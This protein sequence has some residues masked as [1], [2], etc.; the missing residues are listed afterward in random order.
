MHLSCIPLDDERAQ[1]LM[2]LLDGEK[3]SVKCLL[4]MVKNCKCKLMFIFIIFCLPFSETLMVLTFLFFFRDVSQS[5]WV[6]RDVCQTSS[7]HTIC[8]LL[9]SIDL[10]CQ[11]FF[12]RMSYSDEAAD[13]HLTIYAK[14]FLDEFDIQRSC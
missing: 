14:C 9:K 13:E 6:W 1:L 2:L 8:S 3:R 10:L 7:I 11:M 4:W 5:G 12:R